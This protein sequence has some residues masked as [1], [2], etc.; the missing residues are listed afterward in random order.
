MSVG[1]V[2]DKDRT[3][4]ARTREGLESFL[5]QHRSSRDLMEG[6]VFED[7]Q[8]YAHLP[9]HSDVFF[10]K[11]RWAM[12]GE[13][14]AFVDPFYSPGSDFIATANE[15]TASLIES[16]LSGDAALVADKVD[17]FNQY[18]RFK[19]ESVLRLYIGQYPIFGSFEVFRLKYLLD[20]N[21]YY[22][23][24]VWPY[25]ADKLTDTRWLREELRISDRILQAISVMG[26]HFAKM[27]E[28][29][30]LRGEY[31]ARNE[32]EWA[33]GLNGVNQFE[34]RL[35]PMLDPEFR[36][37]EADKAFGSVMAAALE[38]CTELPGLGR[39]ERVLRELTVPTVTLLKEMS[40]SS[41][42]SLLGR[43]GAKMTRELRDE[44]PNA[45]IERVVVGKGDPVLEGAC[46]GRADYEA[47]A[48]RAKAMWDAE[49]DSLAHRVL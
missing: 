34:T 33:N 23:L 9:Y 11:D 4:G 20:F 16:E 15:F 5:A 8:A 3:P 19:Y 2:F 22:N 26:G 30:R 46:V 12:T 28:E 45:G 14:A 32:G 43:I 25:M 48:T 1:L 29:L 31:F 44:Y 41:V 10:S 7:F 42:A 35:G 38:R 6:A 17:A 37:A 21:N 36:K 47:I 39:R 18:Y 49:G 40:E 13:A 24:V 27:G